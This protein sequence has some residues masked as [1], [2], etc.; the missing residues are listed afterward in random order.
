MERNGFIR[1]ERRKWEKE[2]QCS[3]KGFRTKVKGRNLEERGV[4]SCIGSKVETPKG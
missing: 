1:E 3:V 2:Y 4:Q